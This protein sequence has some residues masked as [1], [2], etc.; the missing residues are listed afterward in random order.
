M[1][2]GALLEQ[3]YR[4]ITYDRRGF[5]QSS[6]PITGYDYDTLADD[7]NCLMNQLDLRGAVL[8]GFSMGAGE[9]TRYLSTY[10]SDRVVK[11]V[12]ISG[13][14]PA[15]LKTDDNPEG[16]DGR[17][18]DEMM[19][20]VIKDRPA[21][22]RKFLKDFFAHNLLGGNDVSAEIIDF[23]WQQA[24]MASPIATLRCIPAWLEDFRDDVARIEVPTLI[25]HGDSDRILPIAATALRLRDLL[26]GCHYEEIK[27][28]P[29][30][31]LISHADQVN[32]S[33]LSF[34][35]DRRTRLETLTEVRH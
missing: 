11:A 2:E 3:G 20:G 33:L 34:L 4:V 12:I 18:F 23:S 17:V 6:Q 15:L 21:F 14:L 19:K 22:L 5:G 32:T 13:I 16:V 10:G 8:V 7:L 25:V 31:I 27:G 29:H 1:Q 28:G 9:V 24:V 30:G 26:P 35:A